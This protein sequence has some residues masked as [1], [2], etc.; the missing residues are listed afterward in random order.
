MK[1]CKSCF[2]EFN[3][4]GHFCRWCS[5][6]LREEKRKG[7]PCKACNKI[8]PISNKKF[9]LCNP[10]YRRK[11]ED[12]DP[13]YKEKKRIQKFKSRRKCRGQDP[14]APLMK[15]KNGDGHLDKNG[16][17]QITK[18]GHPNCTSKT[19]R[20][21]QHT[22]LMTQHLGRSLTK[23]ESVHHK[24]GIRDDNRIENLELW[25]KGQPAGQ[26]L[27]DKIEWAKKFLE[28]YGYIVIHGVH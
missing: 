1:L 21:A 15:R 26:R 28:E 11:I 2:K 19:G 23:Y 3:Y 14:E 9:H 22:Y 16:Y 20:I 12:N 17:F 24:N 8:K 5:Q 4:P 18:L 6:K 10:C 25:H 27:E 7:I 13:V